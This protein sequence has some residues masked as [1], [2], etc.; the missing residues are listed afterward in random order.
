MPGQGALSAISDIS[1]LQAVS[2]AAVELL[3]GVIYSVRVTFPQACV[4]TS[5]CCG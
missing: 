4:E 2:F 3:I 5:E 1:V